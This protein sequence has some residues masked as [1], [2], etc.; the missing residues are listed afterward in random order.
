[1]YKPRPTTDS[2]AVGHQT[3]GAVFRVQRRVLPKHASAPITHKRSMERVCRI[4]SGVS[5][6]H[7]NTCSSFQLDQSITNLGQTLSGRLA[8]FQQHFQSQIGPRDEDRTNP[9]F[10]FRPR[11]SSLHLTPRKYP[12]PNRFATLEST[13]DSI[14]AAIWLLQLQHL[15]L[16]EIQ[17][18]SVFSSYITPPEGN[19]PNTLA[20][21][22]HKK[23]KCRDPCLTPG[24]L[25]TLPE[26]I[27]R[28]WSSNTA[29]L[30]GPAQEVPATPKCFVKLF[31]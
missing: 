31:W 20:I 21:K 24:H 14:R 25:E 27:K 16:T 19:S 12:E 28:A 2:N 22:S 18:E 17:R 26:L 13:F 10:S 29:T 15:N 8:H 4:S 5:R 1:M 9:T 23:Q 6:I 3:N 30:W 7:E 11:C